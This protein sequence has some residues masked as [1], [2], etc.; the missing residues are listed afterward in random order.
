M[1]K[2]ASLA[3]SSRAPVAVGPGAGSAAPF[4]P[5]H[6]WGP[7]VAV[8]TACA[9]VVTGP[10]KTVRFGPSTRRLTVTGNAFAAGAEA[11]RSKSAA[12]GAAPLIRSI[13]EPPFPRG[14]CWPRPES[15]LLAWGSTSRLPGEPSTPQWP[16]RRLSARSQWRDRAGV[17][18]D[19]P[20][21]PAENE[22]RQDTRTPGRLESQ[23][24]QSPAT[25]RH[26][27]GD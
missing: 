27:L 9:S 19:F 26:R 23:S 21:P 5:S 7:A 11:K 17:A 24:L 18:P 4:V 13:M 22:R 6:V 1:V 14:L 20:V 15:G 10:S 25:S 16:L 12:T 8:V 2:P 3:A